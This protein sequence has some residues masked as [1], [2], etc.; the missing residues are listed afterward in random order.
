MRPDRS[1]EKVHVAVIGGGLVGFSTA[2]YISETLPQ[3]SVTVISE[4]FSPD[5]TSDVAAG[6][7][8]PHAYPGTL[9]NQ[10][11]NW[12]KE[13]FDYLFKFA[14]SPEAAE[15]G[16]SLVSGWQI[17]KTPPKEEFPYWWEVVL[18][19]RLMTAAEL[20]KFPS[21]RFGQFFTTLKCQASLYLPWM[22]KRFKMNGGHVETGK[23]EN[24]WQLYG[25][26]DAV[27][28][29]TGLGA[30]DML[31]DLSLYPV[32]GHVLEVHAP[33][34]THFIRDGDGSTYIYPG[35]YSTTLGGTRQKGNWNLSPDIQTSKQ[36]L[37][38]CCELEPSLN[39]VRVIKDKVGLRPTRA[40]VR[41]EEEI[42]C[43]DGQR[44]PVIHNYGH[45][46]GGYSVHRGT[47]KAASELLAKIIPLAKNL[48]HRSKL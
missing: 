37:N 46:G 28:N 17:F 23:I 38:R 25:L 27:I 8:I 2:L 40:S 6:C 47:A 39:G 1:P 42:L 16:I 34:L 9:L 12:F 11:K 3:C 18:G 33:W 43:K 30:R 24:I 32:R 29:C 7:L 13:T 22:E 20:A 44:L 31:G 15:A 36:I 35:S 5:T 48:S 26:Y 41:I 4:K 14:N 19:F 45:G 21:Y 10:Q